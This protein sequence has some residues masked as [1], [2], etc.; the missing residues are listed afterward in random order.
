MPGIEFRWSPKHPRVVGVGNDVALVRAVIHALR[1]RVGDAELETVGETAVPSNLQRVVHGIGYVIC[2][3][4]GA[5]ALIGAKR[6]EVYASVSWRG[7]DSGGR[8]VDV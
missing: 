6:I 5:K 2:F 4:N 7:H 3:A 8:L 1:Q